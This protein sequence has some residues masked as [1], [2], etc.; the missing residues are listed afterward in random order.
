[1]RNSQLA[2][3][4]ALTFFAAAVHLTASGS[5]G[6]EAFWIAEPSV[7]GLWHDSGNW[8]T[9]E[10][11][12]PAD[13]AHIDNSG[14]AI[15]DTGSV[16]LDHLFLGE[17]LTGELWQSGGQLAVDI[18]DVQAASRFQLSAGTL[19][20]NDRFDLSGTLDFALGNAEF[21]AADNTVIDW[22]AGTLLNGGGASFAGGV[23]STLY[24][25]LG[26]DPDVFFGSFFSSG[27]VFNVS[28]TTIVVPVGFIM[29]ISEDR[30]DRIRVAGTL[31]P[32]GSPSSPVPLVL[33]QGGVEIA[34][35]GTFNMYGA[36]L[37]IRTSS[38]V[39]GGSLRNVGQLIIADQADGVVRIDQVAGSVS[40]QQDLRVGYARSSSLNPRGTYQIQSG[41][42]SVG[43]TLMI[44]P[45]D[46]TSGFPEGRFA[47][48]GGGVTIGD[49]LVIANLGHASGTYE[50][51][52]GS[53]VVDDGI[54]IGRSDGQP[55]GVFRQAGGSVRANTITVHQGSTYEMQGGS[56]EIGTR[57]D[58]TGTIEFG[59]GSTSFVAPEESIIE[60]S[61][62]TLL[63]DAVN[64][65]YTAGLNSESYFPVG[66]DPGVEFGSFSSGGLVHV[67]GTPL[68]VPAG[69]VMD[70]SSDRPDR[71]R[72][73]GS[74]RPIG[75]PASPSPLVLSQGGVEIAS[76][77][78]FNMY[79]ADLT[80]RAS[81]EVQGG[82]VSNVGH[83]LIADR[84]DSVVRIDQ[85]AGSVS[86]Q[87]HLRVGYARSSSDNP[88][89]TYEIQSGELNVGGI[90]MIAPSDSNN[91]FP[92]GTFVHSGGMVA[93]EY[94]LWIANNGHASGVYEL[95][96]GS[97]DVNNG[98]TIGR[99]TG[100]SHG[101]FRQTGGSVQSDTITVR[102]GSEYEMFGGSVEIGRR[103]DLR[104][105]IDFGGGGASI[106]ASDESIIDWSMGTLVGDASNVN[107]TAGGNSESYFPVGFD[108]LVEFGNF[109]SGGLVHVQGTPL[110]IPTGFVMEITTDRPDRMRVEGTLR[111]AGS[112][113]SPAD[114]VLSQGGVE[115]ASGGTFSMYGADLTIRTSSEVL[116]GSLRN[117][118]QLIIAD[119]ADGVVRIDQVAGSVSVQQD[120]R[121]GY[122]RSSS[123][124]PRGTY[125]IQSGQLSV[126]G[127]LMIAPTDSTSGFPEGRFAQE[128]GGVT[129]GDDL[130]IANL[131]HAS[132]TYELTDG[133]L[134]VDDGITIGR[135]DGQ[136]VGVFRQAGGSV[137]ANTIT[138]HQG[139]TYEMQGGS[140]EIGTRF[141]LTGTIEFGGGST[142]F[143]APEESIIEWSR[144]T[145]LGDAVNVSYT[146]G[147][148]SESYF[149]VGF[150]P[151]VE[152]GSF[153][154]GGL[155]HV[156]GTPLVVPAGFVMDISSDRPDRIRVEGSLRPI[157]SPASPSPLVLSQGGVEIASSGTFNM[158]GADLTVRAS[159]EVQGGSVSNVGHLLI[160]DRP[161]SVVRIDQMAGSVSVQNHLRVGYARSSSDNPRGT[162]EIQSGE[163]N[164]GG[165]LMIAPSDSNN[166]FPEGTFVHSG[167]MV[168]VEY[169]LWIANNGHASGVYELSDGSL[170]VNNGIT[171]GRS[172]GES[173]GV[174]RQTGGSVQSD[175]ITVREGSEYEMFG[176]SV[177]IGRRFDLRGTIDFGGGGASI[178]ASDESIID[179]SMGTLVGDASNVNYTAG[180]NSESYFPVGFNPYMEFGQ[181]A[182]RGLI[183]TTNTPLIIPA[184]F[185]GR[186]FSLNATSIQVS[187]TMTLEPGGQITATTFEVAAGTFRGSGTVTANSFVNDG[188]VAPGESVGVL[189]INGPYSQMPAGELLIELGGNS[190]IG[191]VDR[192]V[193]TGLAA[194]DGR[195]ALT[196]IDGFVPLP[197]EHFEVMTF[198]SRLGEF[199]E[200]VFENGQLP[201]LSFIA[202]YGDTRVRL[203]PVALA[204]DINFD[205]IVDFGDLSLMS[206]SFGQLSG[207]TW[208]E[209]DFDNDGVVGF[210]DLAL[211]APN[212]GVLAGSGGGGSTFGELAAM[213]GR[214]PE[215]GVL[216]VT[217]VGLL[218]LLWLR[219]SGPPL[220]G[221]RGG[222]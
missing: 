18:L 97:L 141:D 111:P 213:L 109:S 166:A 65:S 130:V 5:L 4:I 94:G 42:L 1:M 6:A 22:S 44:A 21:V 208:L 123:L 116:G 60:W 140:I 149:P 151:G 47:Q 216:P 142:S 52:D 32:V 45:T 80:V 174:F 29:D 215:P 184:N 96:D 66:F 88:R 35:G 10:V 81:S 7:P 217:C 12:G 71:I 50:L 73:E 119:Q 112:P 178:L 179:W 120:L 185:S 16:A 98:I 126:G 2:L 198:G 167:G 145:L 195:L 9:P 99:S 102:E 75:S 211:M 157:G 46:S 148:N 139:S 175:T 187:G 41:Q 193:V 23:G 210:G 19:Q 36:D 162:Y 95:S 190:S 221:W 84:P 59:G 31:Q 134:V 156:Q 133:S 173:H 108:P 158:Y 76:S 115:V 30:P 17:T 197:F 86:V 176:G 83:L 204:G 170:D 15:L 78:T 85:M 214:V 127:T 49:D 121:V 131:G 202:D 146:A 150:D 125:Q 122:A 199:Q 37:T 194:L 87:N 40:V 154:S 171:I 53:L 144:G 58:L 188:T 128:G 129:I 164:V 118:G 14:H 13:G 79:G 137:R 57:F 205:G 68:V 91:A 182:S 153:S 39:L 124:N 160:A 152:F 77:G 28:T 189:S 103:F 33:S 11:P 191:G 27:D 206:S 56:I 55:V 114:L 212:F 181:F 61:R 54:T 220:R 136:P 70:I 105:T 177:E 138:V 159:S 64:V 34:S 113:A 143:V 169:G 69:F 147:L 101:V 219:R 196:T 155:V 43:G 203:S 100:E 192:L 186:V 63:G 25:P 132:G 104:G 222:A 74:L 8:S 183:H 26:I 161:D 200:V 165:I 51:T 172:T 201:G 82:S 93:V 168:A 110:V 163:L 117:V 72:V 209:G 38:E 180:S 62:G 89:G 90:L 24:L 92:E 3:G 48:E 107:Y 67:Q 218:G 135:S 20:I 207:S 106:L